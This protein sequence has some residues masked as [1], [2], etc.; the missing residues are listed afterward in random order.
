VHEGYDL[1]YVKCDTGMPRG[2]GG[3][4]VVVIIVVIRHKLH[5]VTLTEW[6]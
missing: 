2:G 4:I 3:E 6:Q 1:T 5:R